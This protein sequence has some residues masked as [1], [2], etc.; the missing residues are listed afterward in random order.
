MF[1]ELT[2]RNLHQIESIAKQILA[3]TPKVTKIGLT[4]KNGMPDNIEVYKELKK[5][6]PDIA[7]VPYYSFKNHTNRDPAMIAYNFERYLGEA[8]EQLAHNILLVSGEPKPKFDVLKGLEFFES[9]KDTSRNLA[10]GVAYNPFLEG[11][12]LEEEHARLEVKL[13]SEKVDAVYLQ[14]GLSESKLLDGLQLIRSLN[15]GVTVYGSVMVPTSFSLS[16]FEMRPWKGIALPA[17]FTESNVRAVEMTR[18]YLN[19][20]KSQSVEPLY[21]LNVISNDGLESLSEIME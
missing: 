10:F 5:I 20:L 13:K 3:I 9:L 17:E 19:V 12:D 7:F 15:P 11:R 8:N 6:L 18:K 14:I 21:S 4:N 16:R 2:V 1:I